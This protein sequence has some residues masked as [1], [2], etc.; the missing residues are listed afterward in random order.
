MYQLSL[1]LSP[2]RA[3]MIYRYLDALD[4]PLFSALS[5]TQGQERGPDQEPAQDQGEELAPGGEVLDVYLPD[6]PATLSLHRDLITKFPGFG[7]QS[8]APQVVAQQD[9]VAKSQQGLPPVQAGRFLI[10]G[11][12]DRDT[13]RGSGYRI[14]IDAAQAFGTAHHGTTRGC[15]LALQRLAQGRRRDHIIKIF[16][17][18]TG[19]GILAIA[20]TRLFPSPVLASDLDPVSVDIT[21]SNARLNAAHGMGQG[22]GRL[23][24][25]EAAG[26]AHQDIRAAMPFD[27]IIA[28]VLANPLKVLAPD[29]RRATRRGGYL[30]LSGITCAQTRRVLARFRNFGFTPMAI[31]YLEDWATL[32]L[33]RRD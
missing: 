1:A 32:T 28:N 19:S 6:L 15:L 30:L 4:E 13:V 26:F 10:H 18:G 12:H 25:I 7:L 8:F 17:L 29:F 24:A 14:E 2:D 3:A 9:W 23:Q 5:L 33:R 20:A 11:S 27:L 16:D 31:E 22:G 21:R